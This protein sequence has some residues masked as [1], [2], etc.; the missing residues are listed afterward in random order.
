M[1]AGFDQIK[2]KD[3]NQSYSPVVSIESLRLLT[4]IAAKLKLDL[5]LF[6]VKT[7]YLYSDIDETVYMTLP[8]GF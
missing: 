1:A 8:P 4:A 7:A 2:G 6:D 3:Y 5:R